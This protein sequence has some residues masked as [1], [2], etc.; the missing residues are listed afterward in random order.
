MVIQPNEKE[1]CVYILFA[2][3]SKQFKERFRLFPAGRRF[4]SFIPLTAYHETSKFS[5]SLSQKNV[6]LGLHFN[7]KT[8]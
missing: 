7:V 6:L 2:N 4:L 5:E 1:A 3:I 8:I